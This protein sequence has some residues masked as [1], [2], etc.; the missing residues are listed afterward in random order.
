MTFSIV[1]RCARTGRFGVAVA[2]S[3][4]AVGARCAFGRAGVGAATT[5]NITDPRLGPKAL[6][7][8]ALG[9]S[10]EQACSILAASAPHREYRQLTMVDVSGRTAC[11]SGTRVL[12]L[13]ASAHGLDVVSAGNLLANTGVPAAIVADFE[14]NEILDLG[15]RIV[16]AMQAGLNAGGEAGPIRSAGLLIAD[17]VDWPIADLRV[18]WSDEP[19]AELAQLWTVW[20]PQMDAYVTRAINPTSAPSYGVPG[21]V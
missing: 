8:M 16:S 14:A 2:S 1:A 3:S 12:G 5:Q 15:P 6:D 17:K 10:A 19:L 7:L 9:A 21:D 13:H 11:Y 20:E 4:P 18:D